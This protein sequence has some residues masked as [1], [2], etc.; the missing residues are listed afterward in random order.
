MADTKLRST[1]ARP[2]RRTHV[3]LDDRADNHL[4]AS[5]VLYTQ[6]LHRPV[7]TSLVVR[8]ALELLAKHIRKINTEGERKAEERTLFL[9]TR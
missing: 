3:L 9:S 1:T 4:S 2:S 5:I 6:M 8:R 7:S